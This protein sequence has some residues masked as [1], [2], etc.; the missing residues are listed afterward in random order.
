[1]LTRLQVSGFKN[2][3]NVDVEFGPYTCIAGPNAAG[4]SNLFDAIEFLALLADHPFAD[5]AQR[6]RLSG[7]RPGDPRTLFHLNGNGQITSTMRFE[8][9]MV[10][11]RQIIDDFGQ[12]APPRSTFLRYTL[13]F[14]YEEADSR[15][16]GRFGSIA[17]VREELAPIIKGDAYSHLRWPH[18]ASEFRN[19]IVVNNRF[20]KYFISTDTESDP[21][22]LLVHADGGSRG[23]PRRSPINAAKRTAVSS[24][25]SADEPTIL[26]ARK[27]MLSWRKLAL[28]PSAMR[29]PDSMFNDP[30]EI[31]PNGSHLASALW[32]L[33]SDDNDVLSLV[34]ANVSAL[35]DVRAVRVAADDARDLLTLEAKLGNGPFLPARSLSDG[36]L[37]FLALSVI[38]VD[39]TF[40]G[41]ICMEEP[42][43]G[44]HPAK[45]P[46]MVN[47]VRGL[48]V[49]PW[50]APGADNPFRQVMVNTHSPEFVREQ[51]AGDL[52]LALP[53]MNAYSG[54]TESA[55]QFFGIDG[56]WRARDGKRA[57]SRYVIDD[58]L[59]QPQESPLWQQLDFSSL[60]SAD[61]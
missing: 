30:H 37:R 36:T 16:P 11:P 15:R 57:V 21:P 38:E 29:A 18:S 28:E 19:Q 8:A 48:A 53:E 33:T 52:V 3:R 13:E 4:K 20:G 25:N 55:V 56:S 46:A 61:Q 58:Y 17:L 5:A 45:I 23:V 41:V 43:N 60:E 26:A 35:T 47:L 44:I 27:E 9:E 49:D 6:L 51:D 50:E 32:R 12:Q 39:P 40:A 31:S 1:M 59:M 24:I 10:V 7:D 42:E 34:A 14:A 2:L 22:S 54:T